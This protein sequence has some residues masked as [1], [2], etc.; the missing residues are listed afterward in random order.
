MNTPTL[1]SEDSPSSL[2]GGIEEAIIAK[3]S[4]SPKQSLH[5]NEEVA[6]ALHSKTHD[7]NRTERYAPRLMIVFMLHLPQ[8]CE[9]LKKEMHKWVRDGVEDD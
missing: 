4:I 5:N 8:P 7:F 3:S 1:T 9:I 6:D 2:G